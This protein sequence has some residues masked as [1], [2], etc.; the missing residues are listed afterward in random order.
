LDTI[1]VR[2]QGVAK[3]VVK[4]IVTGWED[5]CANEREEINRLEGRGNS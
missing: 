3:F 2:Y 1:H 4:D 5:I